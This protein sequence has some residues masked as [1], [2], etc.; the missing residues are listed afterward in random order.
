MIYGG[1]FKKIRAVGDNANGITITKNDDILLAYEN[2]VSLLRVSHEGTKLTNAGKLYM[3]T[4]M[5]MF[6]I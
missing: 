3:L 6:V 2:A 1:D 4:S 5:Q